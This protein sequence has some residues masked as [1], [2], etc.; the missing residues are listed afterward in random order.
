MSLLS[1]LLHIIQHII[2][3]KNY[4]SPDKIS[5]CCMLMC[6]I[7]QGSYF[8]LDTSMLICYICHDLYNFVKSPV[9]PCTLLAHDSEKFAILTSILV[10]CRG[11][12]N[13]CLSLLKMSKL[14]SIHH[15]YAC[16]NV[17]EQGF[18]HTQAVWVE[19]NVAWVYMK[20]SISVM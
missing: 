18:S 8:R 9:T 5:D 3:C 13:A 14:F 20:L 10:I 12:E 16:I 7:Y 19:R 11:S 17:H 4:W 6:T 2:V 15:N 1:F